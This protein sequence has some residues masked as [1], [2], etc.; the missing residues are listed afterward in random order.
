MASTNATFPLRARSMMSPPERGHSM[1]RL[2][3]ASSTPSTVTLRSAG[4][5]SCSLKKSMLVPQHPELADGPVQ[6]HQLLLREG[7][8]PLQDLPRPRVRGAHLSLFLIGEGQYVQDQ[9]LIYLPTVEHVA[10]ALG[11]DLRIVREYDRGREQHGPFTLFPHEHGPR[12]DILTL[13]HGPPKLLRRVGHGDKL[14]PLDLKRGVGRAEGLT[15]RALPI[16]TLPG[17]GVGDPDRQ[18]EDPLP[19]SLG[20]NLDRSTQLAPTTH[21]NSQDLA[22]WTHEL[23]LATPSGDV[24]AYPF[25]CLQQ[26]G[27]PEPSSTY[28]PLGRLVPRQIE[29]FS[30]L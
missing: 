25:R 19:Q 14:S 22:R 1:T 4:L 30:D 8:A 21:E 20:L 12:L 17:G 11:G 26:F 10:R 9:E 27:E 7:L 2:P 24:Y 28:L 16:F 6:V 18:P 13:F 3:L 15:Q 23:F 29:L 5:F